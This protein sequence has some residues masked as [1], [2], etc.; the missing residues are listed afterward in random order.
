MTNGLQ[1]WDERP[2]HK[3]R[4][5]F[6]KVLLIVLYCTPSAR[7][8]RAEIK[9]ALAKVDEMKYI[10]KQRIKVRQQTGYVNVNQK[11]VQ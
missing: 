6:S 9:Q 3:L 4:V 1:R 10:L 2:F 5:F 11:E 8:Q 7:R